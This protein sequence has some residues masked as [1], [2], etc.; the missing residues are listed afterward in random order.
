LLITIDHPSSLVLFIEN[1]GEI[2]VKL[3]QMLV[4]YMRM[5]GVVVR[6]FIVPDQPTNMN[7]FP[8]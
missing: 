4:S 7:V 6:D 2:H 3:L 5:S 1:E 8:L